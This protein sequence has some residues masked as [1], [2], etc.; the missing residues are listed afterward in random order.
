MISRTL[1]LSIALA[2]VLCGAFLHGARSA[3][4]AEVVE[5]ILAVVNDEIVTE[6]DLQIVMAPVLAQYRTTYTGSEFEEKALELRHEFLDK[7]IQER[8]VLSEAKRKQVIVKNEE[9]D[10][11]MTDV[12]N[13][14]PSKEM[15]A[16]SLAEQGMTEKK[17]WNRFR[18]Q[19]M[20]QK[21]VNYEV[22]SKI[23]VSP[24]EVSEYYK[25]HLDEFARGE[26][27]KLQQILIRTDSRTEEE[28]STFAAKLAA[29]IRS[30]KSF[31][32][33]ARE[34]SQGSEAKEGGDMGWV[35]RGQL[36][37]AID[38]LVFALKEGEVTEPFR[39]S[40]GYHIFRVTQKG[41]ASTRPLAEV[42]QEVQ[43]FIFKEKLRIRLEQWMADLKKSAYISIRR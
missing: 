37:G 30:G 42:R 34:Y 2:G 16:A 4:A 8:L 33:V 13:K 9:V 32:D 17:L 38:E 39:S 22:K 1:F 21:L 3:E 7:V 5:R 12:R 43:D 11:M 6:Q 18:D 14:F 40:L 20:T 24:G 25:Q 23:S 41:E 26:R 10:D 36:L 35:E 27:V 15:F 19:L 28:A 29:D 31:E